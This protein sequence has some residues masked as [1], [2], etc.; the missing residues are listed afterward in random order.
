MLK[1][2]WAL[3]RNEKVNYV[4]TFGLIAVSGLPYFFGSIFNSLILFVGVLF[5]FLQRNVIFDTR[6]LNIM[7][8][9][10]LVEFL[11]AIFVYSIARR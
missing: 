2:I 4:I 11:Q 3:D 1:K 7:G 5:I 10:F 8:V 6:S 9:F